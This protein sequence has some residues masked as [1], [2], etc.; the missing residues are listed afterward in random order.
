MAEERQTRIVA[1]KGGTPYSEEREKALKDSIIA[2]ITSAET[3]LKNATNEGNLL[4]STWTFAAATTGAI[5]QHT[6]FTVTGN[7]L[8]QVFGICDTDLDSVGAATISL[9]TA[10]NVAKI[11]PVTTATAIDDGEIWLST[12]PTIEVLGLYQGNGGGFPM[13]VNDGADITMNIL[14]ETITAGAIDFYCLWRPLSSGA[15]VTV[16]TPA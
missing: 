13:V 7:V 2:D 5:G 1:V 8:V 16:T 9:G 15:T 6:L 11:T 14:V 3:T 12:L 4:E 10:G